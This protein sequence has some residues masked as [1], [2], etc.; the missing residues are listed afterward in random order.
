VQRVTDIM[1]EITAASQEQSD[2]IGNVNNAVAQMDEVTQQNAA[3]VEEAAAAAESMQDQAQALLQAVA[4]FRLA[5]G[6]DQQA[7]TAAP[8][9]L[10]PTPTTRKIATGARPKAASPA[11]PKSVAPTAPRAPVTAGGDDDWTEF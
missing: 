10:R 4:V 11:R 7:A 8:I 6:Q 9:L 1:S 3:L 2:G 5:D